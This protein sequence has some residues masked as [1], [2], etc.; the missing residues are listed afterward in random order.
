MQRAWKKQIKT[1][2]M[3]WEKKIGNDE[4]TKKNAAKKF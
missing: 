3:M 2:K 1:Q 4:N